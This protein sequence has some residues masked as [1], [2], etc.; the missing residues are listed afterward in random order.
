MDQ[1]GLKTIKLAEHMGTTRARASEVLSGKRQ[2]TIPM[3]RKLAR[4]LDLSAD[5][6]IGVEQDRTRGS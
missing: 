5:I 2:L 4:S 6:L 1:L 3:I